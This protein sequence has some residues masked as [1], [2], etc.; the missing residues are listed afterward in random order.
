MSHGEQTIAL[1][2]DVMLGRGVAHELAACDP[3]DLW[4]PEL[5]D[6]LRS[7]DAVVLNLE[8]CISERGEPTGLV[9]EKPFF[10]RGPPR[11]TAALN[12][13]GASFAGLANNHALDYGPEALLDTL[14]LLRGAGI[15][16]AGAGPSLE[17]AR[18]GVSI[19]AG[20]LRLGIVA[21]SDH[22]AEFE[23]GEDQP[24]IAFGDLRDGVP[25]WLLGEIARLR[26]ECDTVLAFVHWGPNMTEGPAAWQRRRAAELLEAG[27]DAIAGH[28]AHVFHG[29]ARGESG[30]LL[31]DLGDALDDY[32]VNAQLRN[33]LGIAAIWSPGGEPELELVG[34]ALDFCHTRLAEGEEADWIGRRLKR[35]CDEL[36]TRIEPVGEQRFYI[37][38]K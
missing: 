17:E 6:L 2:G 25:D 38:T 11:A 3:E 5:R 4:S 23:A 36:D 24:G 28:S 15:A 33:D 8:C 29:V 35:A 13:I 34:L 14:D 1:L 20:A 18:R 19:E 12:A 26:D 9:P 37:R 7:C 21:V 22:P 27:A 10:F 31:F 30:P 32:A 16:V